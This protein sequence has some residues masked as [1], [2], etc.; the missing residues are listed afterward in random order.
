LKWLVNTAAAVVVAAVAAAAALGA[1]KL[2]DRTLLGGGAIGPAYREVAR[3]DVHH[4]SMRLLAGGRK[5]HF[6]GDW[7][8][9]CAGFGAP[10]T[11]TFDQVVPIAADGSFTG[12]GPIPG[13]LAS[14]T[15]TFAGRLSADRARASGS[16]HVE[17]AFR[18]NGGDA[19]RAYDCSARVSW[20]ARTTPPA[21]TGK[22]AIALDRAYYGNTSQRYPFVL[23]SPRSGARAVPQ[24]SLM[25]DAK[26]KV[27]KGGTG[28]YMTSPPAALAGDGSFGYTE[29]FDKTFADGVV[30]HY[31]SKLE[32]RFGATSAAGT[33]RIQ[34]RLVNADG[35]TRDTCD[36]GLIAWAA[37]L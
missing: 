9:R 19:A 13:D 25:W 37:A 21:A 31:T 7:N 35:T 32:G 34:L 26:C 17:F 30:G 2:P 10:V 3:F 5:A 14:G 18:P 36:S 23:R 12:T 29:R 33:W 27:Q 16:G 11:A 1:G 22:A 28:G 24:A 6:Y 8:S 4:V 20:Q 15:F